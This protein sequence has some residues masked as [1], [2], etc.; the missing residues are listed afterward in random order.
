MLFS[1]TYVKTVYHRSESLSNLGPRIWNFLPSTLKEL[2]DANSFKTH[3][4]KWQ[5]EN[6]PCRL[7]KKNR[8]HVGFI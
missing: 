6:C 5:P 2:N 1:I 8:P 7:C 4:K 3:I